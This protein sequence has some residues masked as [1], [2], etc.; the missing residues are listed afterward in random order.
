MN[1]IAFFLPDLHALTLLITTAVY[2]VIA[3]IALWQHAQRGITT[4]WL[5][6]LAVTAA[7]W[8]L[9]QLSAHWGW[10]S[11]ANTDLS[12]RLALYAA[13]TFGGL[14]VQF[15]RAFLRQGDPGWSWLGLL[16]AWL[17]LAAVLI[18]LHVGR[19]KSR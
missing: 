9:V 8:S 5:G 18:D 7:S 2:A 10:F 15:C 3:V 13:L 6:L 17:V 12:E 1:A 14:L 16:G 11:L 4:D 19:N